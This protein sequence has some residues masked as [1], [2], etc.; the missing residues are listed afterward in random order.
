[1]TRRHAV[2][3]SFWSIAASKMRHSTTSTCLYIRMEAEN[4]RGSA[5]HPA[6]NTAKWRAIVGA[7]HTDKGGS[8]DASNLPQLHLHRGLH[9]SDRPGRYDRHHHISPNIAAPPIGCGCC[10]RQHH[11]TACTALRSE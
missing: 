3:G 9:C 11:S 10:G 8:H 5:L 4:D 7:S 2:G 6:L 1:M